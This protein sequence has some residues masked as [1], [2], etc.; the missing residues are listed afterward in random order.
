MPSPPRAVFVS[1]SALH[2]QMEHVPPQVIEK[3]IFLLPTRDEFDTFCS[4]TPEDWDHGSK[5]LIQILQRKETEKE[6]FFF[7]SRTVTGELDVEGASRWLQG[8]GYD[9]LLEKLRAEAF[10]TS[11]MGSEDSAWMASVISSSYTSA[12][13]RPVLMFARRQVFISY[14]QMA[15]NLS[16]IPKKVLEDALF[17]FGSKRMWFFPNTPEEAAE[18]KQQ[19]TDY[20][21]TPPEFLQLLREKEARGQVCFLKPDTFGAP[22]EVVFGDYAKAS[23]WLQALGFA[24]LIL[25]VQ[26]WEDSQGGF[27]G[28]NHYQ[29]GKA[30]RCVE[31]FTK[32]YHDYRAVME[33]L[34]QSDWG[35]EPVLQWNEHK[36][37]H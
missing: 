25:D 4:S 15:R 17:F 1:L 5:A 35:L 18:A 20:L 36:H 13:L 6:V 30:Q 12:V 23:V 3:G 33:L 34:E 9:P 29:K 16:K 14:S 22:D 8:L 27:Q 24:P 28:G 2:S 26:W 11:G 21:S 31:N 10:R 7:R 37:H 32:G 19:P